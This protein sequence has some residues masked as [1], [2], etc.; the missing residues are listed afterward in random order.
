MSRR[1]R[2]RASE[3]AA[4]GGRN[5]VV[6]LVLVGVGLAFVLFFRASMSD[7]SSQLFQAVVGNPEL[8]LPVS[9]TDGT[10]GRTERSQV[11]AGGPAAN[12]PQPKNQGRE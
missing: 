11:D 9:V 8:E 1:P 4:T 10:G 5:H 6:F 3:I 2:R 7:S 12:P